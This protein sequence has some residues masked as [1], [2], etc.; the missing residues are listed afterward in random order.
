[1]AID[2][3][4]QTFIEYVELD[5]VPDAYVDNIAKR[6]VTGVFFGIGFGLFIIVS[7]KKSVKVLYNETDEQR[8]RT[9]S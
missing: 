5:F 3:V 2:G 1:M 6:I 8:K 9:E 7:L 4:F